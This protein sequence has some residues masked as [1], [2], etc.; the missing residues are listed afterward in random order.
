M[1]TKLVYTIAMIVSTVLS[2]VVIAGDALHKEFDQGNQAFAAAIMNGDVEQAVNA[3]TDTACV[4]APSAKN[5][6]GR[7]DILAFW[8]GVVESGVKDVKIGTGEVGSSGEL[9]YVTGTLEVTDSTG[10]VHS[11]RYVLVFKKVAGEWKLHIDT[12][13]PS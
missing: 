1:N 3:Y 13:T 7:E 12:W 4:I 6:C 2:N 9:A 11:S 10:V 8:T 5:A